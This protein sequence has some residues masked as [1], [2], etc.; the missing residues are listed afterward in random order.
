M[1]RERALKAFKLQPTDHIPMW[2]HFSNPDAEQA[3]TGID[4]Y[5]HPKLAREKLHAMTYMDVGSI[6]GSDNPIP[7]LE[8]ENA[9]SFTDAEGRH[10]VRW[11][12]GTTWHWDWGHKI[13]TIEEVL[14]YSPLKNPD[15]R[16]ADVVENRDYSRSVEDF[17]QEFQQNLNFARQAN[18][19]LCLEL[20]GFYNTLFMWPLLTF[21]WELFLELGALYK[22]ECKRLFSEFAEFSRKIMKAWAMTDVDV[23]VCHDD[24]CFQRGPVFS[25][26]WLREMVYPYYEEFWSIL[27]DAGKIVIFMSDGNVDQ[28]A[29][30]VFA[31]G[32]DGISSEPYTNFPEIAKK[33]PDKVLAGDGDN[34]ILSTGDR[35]AI[36]AMVKNMAEWGKQY[37]GYFFCI[38]NHI[39]WNLPVD[40]VKA[41]FEAAA[42][43][44]AR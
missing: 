32:A 17:A 12:T 34:R 40:A 25:P 29:D 6:P 43:Y 23:V 31:C 41:Y 8:D 16:G 14:A 37:P 22:E 2:E 13:T 26:D 28:V 36:F 20:G 38:G 33:H 1:D 35:D 11:G 39:P 18:G 19:N 42:E 7:R 30:D 3:I 27:H 21:G 24:I 10:S 15:M 44:G 4:P 5:D 9:S